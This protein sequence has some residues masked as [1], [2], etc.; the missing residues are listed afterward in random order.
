MKDWKLIAD[1]LRLDLSPAD[2][3]RITPPLD[4][5]EASFRPLAANI[6]YET[7]PALAFEA[8]AE[9]QP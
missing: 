3:E 7:E 9:E 4:A 1:G 2:I 5:L 6:P 8:L